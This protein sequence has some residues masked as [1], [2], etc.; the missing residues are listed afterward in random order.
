MRQIMLVLIC[1]FLMLAYAHEAKGKAV[2]DKEG[3]LW[4][5]DDDGTNLKQI[6]HGRNGGNTP[7]WSPDGTQI[8]FF[9]GFPYENTVGK[10]TIIDTTGE[11][12]KSFGI[13][14][15]NIEEG[16]IR[17]IDKLDWI[18]SNRIGVAGSM[19]PSTDVYRIIDITSGKEIKS[20]FGAK[21]VWSS[22]KDKIAMRGWYPQD[23]PA[24]IKS[25]YIQI[26]EESIYPT[27]DEQEQEEIQ[28]II[29]RFISHIYWSSDSG[30]L[31]VV[32]QISSGTG[33]NNFL[34]IINPAT[35]TVKKITLSDDIK[36]IT[37]IYWSDNKQLIYLIGQDKGWE[38]DSATN[39]ITQLSNEQLKAKL[40]QYTEKLRRDKL[41][42]DLDGQGASW[43]SGN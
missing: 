22:S 26:N 14:S 13:P 41:I 9:V 36:K 43:F 20:Y 21:F 18:D 19:D 8:A 29:H 40:P 6:T 39:S 1:F 27:D 10:L 15:R 3:D 35:K 34:V 2:F 25:D 32:D 38:L 11:I 37:L 7:V 16:Y 31:A 28:K 17:F 5:V 33:K 12:I 23:A 24:E 30:Q 42:E 4:M